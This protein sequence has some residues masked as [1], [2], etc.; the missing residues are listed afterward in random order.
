[1]PEKLNVKEFEIKKLETDEDLDKS[2]DESYQNSQ[3][4]NERS[5]KIENIENIEEDV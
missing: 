4:F 2:Y 3:N 1:M 5:L